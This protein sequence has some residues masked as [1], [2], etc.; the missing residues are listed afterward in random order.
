MQVDLT[1]RRDGTT[2][3]H[4][5]CHRRHVDVVATLL[6]AGAHAGIRSKAGRTP[7]DV[8]PTELHHELELLM[9]SS[10]RKESEKKK[11]LTK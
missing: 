4:V 10:A 11:P 9:R 5:A 6:S 7:L 3:L 2:P 1:I 8:A